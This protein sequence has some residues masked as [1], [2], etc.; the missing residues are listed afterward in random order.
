MSGDVRDTPTVA[1]VVINAINDRPAD[2]AEAMHAVMLDKIREKLEG[3][4]QEMAAMFNQSDDEEDIE[5]EDE[6]DENDES[7]DEFEDDEEDEE[8]D[9]ENA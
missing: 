8:T 9:G 6:S 4:R 2:A 7:D 5:V 3:K 1:D